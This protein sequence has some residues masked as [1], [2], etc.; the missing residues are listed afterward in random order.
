MI[1]LRAAA[2]VALVCFGQAIADT[3]ADEDAAFDEAVKEFG[4]LGG[5]AW[6]CSAGESQLA[7]ERE[8]LRAFNGIAQLFGTDQAFY[9]AALFGA[10]AT[11]QIEK[12][13]CAAHLENCADGMK[14][15]VKA[16]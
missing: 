11:G 9:F 6:Q 12:E 16:E 4:Y 7:I 8:V 1:T 10:G 2:L 15:S 3:P 14:S 5:A 13:K